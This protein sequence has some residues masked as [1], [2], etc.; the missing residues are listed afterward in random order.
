VVVA[1]MLVALQP[2]ALPIA[3]IFLAFLGLLELRGVLRR[4]GTTSRRSSS[5]TAVV[6]F[7][8][9]L[10]AIGLVVEGYSAYGGPILAIHRPG[11]MGR[12][13]LGP[14]GPEG[15]G[16]LTVDSPNRRKEG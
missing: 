10:T 11:R 6:L 5:G 7:L 13:R 12:A 2:F 8:V 1:Q 15:G 14:L 16:E 4:A 9:A 3:A